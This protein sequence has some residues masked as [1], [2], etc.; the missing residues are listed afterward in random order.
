VAAV[1]KAGARLTM[2][3]VHPDSIST[4]IQAGFDCIEHGTGLR[5]EHVDAMVAKGMAFT[6][7][8]MIAPLIPD[9]MGPM[10]SEHGMHEIDGWLSSHPK[11]VAA[12]AAAGVKILAGSDAAMWP[13]GLVAREVAE[14]VQAGIP[15]ARAIAAASWDARSYF[16]FPGIEEGAP[17]D[18]VV[19]DQ[20]PRKDVH[21]LEKPALI[22]LDGKVVPAAP[23]GY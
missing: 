4:A 14:M 9:A 7:T 2:H 13:H 18:L 16:G 22:I 23:S 19:F 5:K 8:L 3:A 1:H 12:A 17:A 15:A 11:R 21:A 6:P 20:D 10:C